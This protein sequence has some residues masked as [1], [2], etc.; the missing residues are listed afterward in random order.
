M[1]VEL[2]I[3]RVDARYC[4]RILA[5]ERVGTEIWTLMEAHGP[6][7]TTI[8]VRIYLRE[9]RP[10]RLAALGE[11]YWSSL[12]CLRDQDEAM[13]IRWEALSTRSRTRRKASAASLALGQLCELR[14]RLPLLVEFDRKPFR[15]L[16]LDDRALF[17]PTTIRQHWLAPLED[18]VSK[19]GKPRCP[20][21]GCLF[22]VRTG[23][24]ADGRGYR[25]AP[26]PMVVVD[27]VTNEI[28]LNA[29]P[30]VR[31]APRG[32][33]AILSRKSP[34]SRSP[35]HRCGRARR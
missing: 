23:R 9:R 18:A 5:G 27:P 12:A 8:E 10:G 1:V 30:A 22:D 16:E 11:K 35:A 4:A 34:A 20:W 19:N 13:M 2:R 31:L 7:R 29:N 14:Q 24:S 21:H 32:S 33:R 15:V 25:L 3:D 6:Q 26:G 17:A 28:T